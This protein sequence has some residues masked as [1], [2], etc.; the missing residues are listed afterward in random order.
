[1]SNIEDVTTRPPGSKVFSTLGANSG[2][3]HI[4]L[5]TKSSPPTAAFNTPFGR[6]RYLRM[7]MGIK[8]ASELS[9]E[10]WFTNSEAWKEWRLSQI[11][12]CVHGKDSLEHKEG[13]GQSESN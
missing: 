13:S 10:K 5:S 3:F 7:Q 8:S 6:Y 9:S 2:Y 4:K 12:Y 11:T 1:M